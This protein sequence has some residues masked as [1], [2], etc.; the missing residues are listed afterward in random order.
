VSRQEMSG[1]R[2][3]RILLGIT[4]AAVLVIIAIIIAETLI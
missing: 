4:G 2:I 1:P 3:S